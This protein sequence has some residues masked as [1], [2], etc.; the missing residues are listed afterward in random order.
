MSGRGPRPVRGALIA[1]GASLLA[2]GDLVAWPS[3]PLVP[4][5]A[6]TAVADDGPAP[7]SMI[8]PGVLDPRDEP[9]AGLSLADVL[10][11][12][13][14][15]D[16][17]AAVPPP[18]PP[19]PEALA[20]AR[21]AYIEG[22]TALA[23]N[24]TLIAVRALERALEQDPGSIDILTSLARAYQRVGNPAKAAE[25]RERVLRLDPANAEALVST[26]W[27]AIETGDDIAVVNAFGQIFL[28][29]ESERVRAFAAMRPG[30][31]S[32]AELALARSLRRLSADAA[33][34]E[35]LERTTRRAPVAG[36]TGRAEAE[37]IRALGDTYARRGNIPAAVATWRSGAPARDSLDVAILEPRIA[38]GLV[39]LDRTDEA[40]ARLRQRA[41]NDE[42]TDIDVAIAAWLRD[43]TPTNAALR[44]LGDD[45]A[46]A[47]ATGNAAFERTRLARAITLAPVPIER[48]GTD[49]RALRDLFADR[50]RTGGP[51]A[52]V[53][54]ANDVL[55][56]HP[57]AAVAI[58]DALLRNG[59]DAPATLDAARALGV[60][61]AALYARLLGTLDDVGP[62]WA[63]ISEARRS[64]PEDRAILRAALVTAARL[65]EASLVAPLAAD[66]ADD[67]ALTLIDLAAAYRSVGLIDKGIATAEAATKV[68]TVAS[69]ASPVVAAAAHVALAQARADSAART[70]SVALAQSAVEAATTAVGLDPSN[71]D[72]WTVLV[73]LWQALS[74]GDRNDNTALRAEAERTLERLQAAMPRGPVARGAAIERWIAGGAAIEAA[75]A[76]AACSAA[77]LSES[78]LLKLLVGELVRQ[79]AFETALAYLDARLAATPGDAAAWQLWTEASIAAGRAD[80]AL[81]RLRERM[82]GDGR[83]PIAVRLTELALRSLDRGEEADAIAATRAESLPASPRRSLERAAQALARGDEVT[84]IKTLNAATSSVSALQPIELLAAAELSSR[85]RD[86]VSRSPLVDAFAGALIQ[87]AAKDP[88]VETVAVARAAALIALDGDPGDDPEGQLR[89]MIETAVGRT[90]E[91]NAGEVPAWLAI[92]QS[93]ADRSRHEDGAAFLAALL[94]SEARIDTTA[95]ARLARACFALDAAAGGGAERSIAILDLLRSRGVRPFARNDRPE[96]SDADAL[97]A[98]ANLYSLVGDDRGM[99]EILRESLKR[100]PDHAMSLNNLAWDALESGVVNPEVIDF[101]ERAHKANPND[102]SILDTVGWLRYLQGLDTDDAGRDGSIT[103]LR[104]AVDRSNGQPSGEV[105]D[106]LGDALWRTGDHK[107]AVKAWQAAQ[108]EIETNSP[109]DR[110]VERVAGYERAEHGVVVIDAEAL[111]RRQYGNALERVK[112]KL[113]AVARGDPPPI[114]TRKDS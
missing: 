21:R 75:Q 37:A 86:R 32:L 96:N 80:Q 51:D 84:A 13:E 65:G 63:A 73:L 50:L 94:R 45:L 41:E 12:L 8:L 52:A 33:T 49:R 108:R 66:V 5:W 109:K 7:P 55:A 87:A 48:C 71:E 43:V 23:E 110:I 68:S 40:V 42:T 53:K 99:L 102:A 100:D 72:A 69:G 6:A 46:K 76:A 17:P 44:A 105:L 88:A 104:R 19:S 74:G 62:A 26:G 9:I 31:E 64:K 18:P 24:R 28:L 56:A 25:L 93:F 57:E 98:L 78:R 81:E 30:A 107:E 101:A 10:D 114:A 3:A 54:A 35:V 59:A 39:A 77:D 111:W 61:G 34:I 15:P 112:A 11:A 70:A 82:D 106:H 97:Q 16:K 89:R 47:P 91:V 58:V 27:R 79:R 90:I 4:A 85:V 22:R 2:T 14:P 29:P 36:T 20:N 38:W 67:D 60:A 113:A 83:D 95:S 92:G 1:L 103:L